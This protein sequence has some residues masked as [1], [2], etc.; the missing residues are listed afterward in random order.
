[1][2]D[3]LA[4]ILAF[5][6]EF[7]PD[8]GLAIALLTVTVMLLLTP[9]T[10]KGTRSMMMMQTIQ[11]EMKRLQ[12]Q[13]RDDRPKLNEEVLKLYREN[14]I[15]PLA[16]CLPLLIQLPVFFILYRVLSGLTH[17]VPFTYLNPA[18]SGR[19]QRVGIDGLVRSAFEPDY[20]S[21]SSELFKSLYG[22]TQMKSWGMDLAE[23]STKAMSH[24][25][26]RALPYF[27]LI[28]G[29]FITSV[30]QQ[31]Q[32]SGRNPA[33]ASN[34]QQQMLMKLGPIMITGFS[35]FAPGGLVIYFFVSNLFR[36]GQQALISHTIYKTPEAKEL[37]ARQSVEAK[38]KAA[39]EA[40]GPKKGFF[41]RMLG[42]A[43]PQVK[44]QRERAN[45]ARQKA[46]QAKAAKA[47][48]TGANGSPK[49][50]PPTKT[51]QKTASP[52]TAAKPPLAK[53]GGGRATPPGA[54]PSASRKKRK[55]K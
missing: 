51:D 21:R 4:G 14:N 41:E 13:Y 12:Q 7:I 15:N 9:L 52:R 11:P 27:V 39:K 45:G 53:S 44:D 28:V 29:V 38:E 22:K 5:F 37:L 31:R 20:I 40:A 1:M 10:L 42:E 16:G 46:A 30:I 36:V 47:G 43:A 35:I 24:S 23:S 17:T 55:R 26:G 33:A 25:L 18:V 6:Y 19:P 48:A 34:P 3:L 32:I 50:A 54:R 2:F 8:Y 49:A